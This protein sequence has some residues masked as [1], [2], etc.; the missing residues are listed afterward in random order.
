ML[1]LLRLISFL[2]SLL[3]LFPLGRPVCTRDPDFCVLLWLK[4]L[5][6]AWQTR[7]VD[8]RT[9]RCGAAFRLL[10]ALQWMQLFSTE[11]ITYRLALLRLT[12]NVIEA[13]SFFSLLKIFLFLMEIKI[14]GKN[15]MQTS[16]CRLRS[17]DVEYFFILYV[18]TVTL[19]Q[20]TCLLLTG[21]NI[22][23]E[24]VAVL[25]SSYKPLSSVRN[26]CAYY[27]YGHS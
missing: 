4:Q 19:R 6:F 13:N 2:G 27:F 7:R 20:H 17:S 14:E 15:I 21:L 5:L 16:L 9:E 26:D 12:S 25:T 1:G 24:F 23:L 10:S 18:L 11:A 22:I 3:E 8:S